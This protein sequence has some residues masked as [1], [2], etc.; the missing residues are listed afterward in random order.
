MAA[1]FAARIE[2]RPGLH[3]WH[4]ELIIPPYTI[5]TCLDDGWYEWGIEDAGA[6]F[7]EGFWY[8]LVQGL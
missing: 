5:F 6:R 7:N 4:C 2:K 3:D 1:D 8:S